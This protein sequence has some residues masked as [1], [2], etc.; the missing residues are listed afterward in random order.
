MVNVAL[1]DGKS[2]R[3]FK[4]DCM[5]DK[6][7]NDFYLIQS[8]YRYSENSKIMAAGFRI[9]FSKDMGNDGE[10]PITTLA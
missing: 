7:K 8:F 10:F 4:K 5:V 2:L 9:T 6:H 3:I 1:G